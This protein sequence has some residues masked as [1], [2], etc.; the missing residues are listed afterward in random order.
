MGEMYLGFF[1]LLVGTFFAVS[2]AS[3]TPSFPANITTPAIFIF[4]DSTADVG[5]NTFLPKTKIKANFPPNGIDFPNSRPTGRFSNGFNSADYLSK[6]MGQ[7]RSPQPFLFLLK[8]GLRKRMFRGVNFAS[9]ASGL[10]DGT[11][12]HLNVVSMSEQ[13]KQFKTVHG[14]LTLVKGRGAT[15]NIIAKS[16]FAI[17]V[18]SNDIF[19]YFEKQSTV[20]P[21]I[22]IKSLMAAYECHIES[23]YNLGARKFGII[24]VP[25]VGCCPSQRILNVTGGCFEIENTFAR[26][27]HSSLDSLLKKLA[28]KLSG[29]KYSLG[30]SYEMTINVINFPQLFIMTRSPISAL[31]LITFV[32]I[33]SPRLSHAISRGV[34]IIGD[35]LYDVG[36]N[37]YLL[38]TIAKANFP[39]YGIDFFNRT[40]NG[41]FCN[42]QNLADFTTKIALGET[43]TSPPPYQ[44]IYGKG[45]SFMD[46]L[47]EAL[48]VDSK[49]HWDGPIK[50]FTK[51]STGAKENPGKGINFASS[52][53]GIIDATSAI[54]QAVS[55]TQQLSEVKYV[56]GNLSSKMGVEKAHEYFEKSTFFICIGNNDVNF[57]ALF[58]YKLEPDPYIDK[59]IQSYNNTLMTLYKLG[60]RKF[61]IFGVP[62]VGCSP[63]MRVTI[64]GGN[65]SKTANDLAQQ[66]NIKLEGVLVRMKE[67]LDDMHFSFANSYNLLYDIY[68]K[69]KDYKIKYVNTACCGLG[70]FNAMSNCN[71]IAKVCKD[72]TAYLFWDVS[73]PS[74]YVAKLMI[75][76]FAFGKPRYVGPITWSELVN[77]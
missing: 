16:V 24:S 18:G 77:I 75:E 64:K 69:P 17:S 47:M 52:G 67:K 70:R 19:G 22:F 63:L 26:A 1:Y 60:A 12:K 41:R 54:D 76:K 15:K 10:L 37:T 66:F 2:Q 61:G 59:L 5:T 36:T 27:F 29:M 44:S 6:L 34:F 42:G 71:P 23:L 25:P 51:A 11:G 68:M 38:R 9:G 48:D 14:N 7:K 49:R 8:A 65:C 50:S 30:N 35:S 28:C 40:P 39:W 74:Q 45:I 4:G 43:V 3:T 33:L 32:V 56:F 58:R 73:H 20:D 13:I 53:C 72:R 57:F 46:A 31:V 55:I 21:A 62:Y